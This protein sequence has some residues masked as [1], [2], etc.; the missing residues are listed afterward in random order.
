MFR[1]TQQSHINNEPL[2]RVTKVKSAQG[3][4]K[5]RPRTTVMQSSVCRMQNLHSTC[6]LQMVEWREWRESDRVH[7][8]PCGY[9]RPNGFPVTFVP[10]HRWHRGSPLTL[11]P[12]LKGTQG[13][14]GVPVTPKS[15][16][17]SSTNTDHIHVHFI[18]AHFIQS[19]CAS[20]A[21]IQQTQ[22]R[23]MV[24]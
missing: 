13:P 17:W 14:C 22:C 9:V 8:C 21:T 4:C 18:C 24:L 5:F 20:T 15:C 12:P 16:S 7:A 10:H 1:I 6:T 3:G 11:Y 2:Q 23:M 19:R